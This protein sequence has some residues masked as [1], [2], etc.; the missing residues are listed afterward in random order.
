M[1]KGTC[2][3][4]G[5]PL[6]ALIDTGSTHSFV[7]HA[8]VKQLELSISLMKFDLIVHTPAS[9]SVETSV[10]C[11]NCPLLIYDRTFVVDLI[12]LPLSQLD[13]ILGMD[14]LSSN[15]VHLNCFNKSVRFGESI[16]SRDSRFITANQ[17]NTSLTEDAKL[18]IMM[19]SLKLES[20]VMIEDV[21]VVCDF[22][23]VFPEDIHSLP[24][25]RE[26]EFSIDLVPGTGPI[27]IA[28][29]RMS[30]LEL[31]ELKKQLEELLEKQFVR[32]SVSPW[33]APV[34]LVKKKDETM[35]L[36]VDYRQL[37][38]VT[39]KNKYPLPGIDDLMDQLVGACVFSKI[40][41][42]SGYHQIRVKSEDVP[43]TA[44]RTR[45]GHY[46]Y[47]VM[48]FGVT[49][50]PGVFMEHMNRIFHPYL[51]K[52]VVVFIDD[53]LVYSKS[54]EERVEHLRK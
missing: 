4:K 2:F 45:Y 47:L 11:F 32:P 29:Y 10:A 8:C 37:N 23:E 9:G 24:P 33:G 48:P 20:K 34:L 22:R 16:E 6:I 13:V 14:W 53:I 36:C 26:V 15:H 19:A 25:E 54:K 41:L 50:A 46:E 43:K 27:S 7:S 12:C 28:P 3:I 39:I 49:N 52:F 40:D 35:R 38:K 51:D 5:T 1:I 44:F 18:Y 17:V 42:R 31:A 30:P 21:P